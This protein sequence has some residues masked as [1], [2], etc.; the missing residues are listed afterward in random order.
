MARDVLAQMPQR[1]AMT[2]GR[3]ALDDDLQDIE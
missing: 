1:R 3:Q 2:G